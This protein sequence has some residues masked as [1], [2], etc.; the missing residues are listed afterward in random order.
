VAEI[1][2]LDFGRNHP[3]RFG[4]NHPTLTPATAV[5][6]WSGEMPQHGRQN[7]RDHQGNGFEYPES[8]KLE[9]HKRF[10]LFVPA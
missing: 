10:F 9:Y 2:R 7:Q 4:E 6:L 5:R 3:T 1:T 8:I